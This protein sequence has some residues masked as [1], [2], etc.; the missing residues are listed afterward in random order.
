MTLTWRFQ[1]C[2]F[3]GEELK[4]YRKVVYY[5]KWRLHYDCERKIQELRN[6]RDNF[7]TSVYRLARYIYINR[8]TKTNK[9]VLVYQ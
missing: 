5:R 8:Q 6:K 4:D 2:P 9:D 1:P 3:C 7:N